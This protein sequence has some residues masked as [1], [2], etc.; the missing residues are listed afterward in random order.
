MKINKLRESIRE[1]ILEAI[2]RS[3]YGAL[4]INAPIISDA[5]E[6]LKQNENALFFNNKSKF[7]SFL[8]DQKYFSASYSHCYYSLE[9]QEASFKGDNRFRN[10]SSGISE[11]DRGCVLLFEVGH[12]LAAVWSEKDKCGYIVP[13]DTMNK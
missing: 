13:S 12:E 11:A 1:I 2:V 9:D 5:I 4:T 8:K 7:D 10:G 6:V 3:Q